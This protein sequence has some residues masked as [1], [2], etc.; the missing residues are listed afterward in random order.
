MTSPEPTHSF[1]FSG[2]ELCLDFA[3]TVSDHGRSHGEHLAAWPDLVAWGEQAGLLAA[4]EADRIRAGNRRRP[5]LVEREFRRAVR[6]RGCLYRVF[7]DVAD[8]RP[9][10]GRDLEELNTWTARVMRH[11]RLVAATGGLAWGWAW[12]ESRAPFDRLLWPVVK[13]AADLLA[14]PAAAD[15]RECASSTCTWLFL[16][17]SRTKQRRWCSMQTCGNRAKVHRFYERQ[18]HAAS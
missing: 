3:N 12:T 18:R 5:G 13:S 16:D 1:E 15:V 17:R 14:S 2:G 7:S 11:A 10:A 6:L 4:S 8:G 9:P